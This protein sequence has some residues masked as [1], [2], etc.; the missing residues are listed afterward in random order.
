MSLR[1][2]NIDRRPRRML[3]KDGPKYNNRMFREPK[4]KKLAD[5]ITLKSISGSEKAAK[6]LLA[7][8]KKS[9]R[10]Y[11]KT[12]KSA[13][14]LAANRARILAKRVHNPNRRDELYKIE[15]IYRQCYGKMKLK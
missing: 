5:I 13:T 8:F 14:V 7:L 2:R 15:R 6:D 11:Q 10:S 9:N 4:N 3:L 12:I 1:R